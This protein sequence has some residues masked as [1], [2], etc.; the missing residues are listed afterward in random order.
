MTTTLAEM[1]TEDRVIVHSSATTWQTAIKAAAAPLVA[2]GSIEPA[3]VDAMI[4]AV[5][6]FG[7]YIVLGPHVALAHARPD[8]SVNRQAMSILTLEHPVAFGHSDHDPVSVV[9][10]LASQDSTSHLSALKSFVRIAGDP[11]RTDRL[12]AATSTPEVLQVLR[13]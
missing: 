3:Y 4:G 5:E 11:D 13:G 8:G 12:A 9:F 7:P 6:K 10:C 2:D 1:I